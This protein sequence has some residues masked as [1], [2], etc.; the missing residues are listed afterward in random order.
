MENT[1][2]EQMMNL[3][4][5]FTSIDDNVNKM[6]MADDGE[7]LLLGLNT[8]D[9]IGFAAQLAM[10]MRENKGLA[11]VITMACRAYEKKESKNP[12]SEDS[13][14]IAIDKLLEKLPD[15]ATVFSVVS[16]NGK[17][18]AHIKGET[19]QISATLC[20]IQERDAKAE[21]ILNV[22]VDGFRSAKRVGFLDDLR[23]NRKDS[24]VN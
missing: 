22:A 19:I 5:A 15:S 3:K 16:Y 2:K 8:K 13:R 4:N 6:V 24:H 17:K 7:R 14:L 21:H 11:N 20:S 12:I 9:P 23:N 1:K 10:Q 18:M